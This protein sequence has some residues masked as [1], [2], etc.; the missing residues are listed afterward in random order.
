MHMSNKT[1]FV[2]LFL[3][4]VILVP[5][6]TY[7]YISKLSF[8]L[9]NKHGSKSHQFHAVPIGKES[10]FQ[11]FE[12]RHRHVENYCKANKRMLDQIHDN[13]TN[14]LTISHLIFKQNCYV[15][16]NEPAG[17]VF[18]SPPKSGSSETTKAIYEATLD[19]K[20]AS[21]K[22]CQLRFKDERENCVT[23]SIVPEKTYEQVGKLST[24]KFMFFRHPMDRLVS[25]WRHGQGVSKY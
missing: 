16:F 6:S 10:S 25:S 22:W 21:D 24:K 19:K 18:C 12:W 7:I 1:S 3:L 11:S 9:N 20:K 15:Y 13:F 2:T 14:P 17:L 8:S 5:L 4:V 23:W